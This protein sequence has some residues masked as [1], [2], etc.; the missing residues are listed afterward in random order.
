MMSATCF[1]LGVSVLSI[2]VSE[3]LQ[4]LAS[5]IDYT[6][7]TKVCMEFFSAPIMPCE[8]GALGFQEE[9]G[10]EEKVKLSCTFAKMN[11][12]HFQGSPMFGASD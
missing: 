2:Q 1:V 4:L 7:Q 6:L 3:N 12:C 11:W 10:K 5:R 8:G 9:K